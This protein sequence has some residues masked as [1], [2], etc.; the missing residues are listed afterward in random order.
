MLEDEE[1]LNIST[2][3]QLELAKDIK[4]LYARLISTAPVEPVAIENYKLQLME[5]YGIDSEE[6]LEKR[7]FGQQESIDR[8]NQDM[9]EVESFG[10]RHR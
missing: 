10:R 7:L 5:K 8:Q 4:A 1:E 6:E 2:S 9:D 3:M